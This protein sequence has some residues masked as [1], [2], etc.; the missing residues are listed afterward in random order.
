MLKPDFERR[1]IDNTQPI[2]H[3]FLAQAIYQALELGVTDTVGE[4]PGIGTAELAQRL[5]LDPQRLLGLLNFLQNEGHVLDDDGWNLTAKGAGVRPFA[6]WYEMLIGGYASTMLQLGDALRPGA[7][8]AERDSTKVGSGS[9][10]I[11]VHDTLPLVEHLLDRAGSTPETVVDLGCGD[12]AFLIEMLL[13][14]PDLRGIGVDPTAG[15]IARAAALRTT[16]GVANRLELFQGNAADVAKLDLP[17]HGRGTCFMTAF[18]LQEMLEQ[19]GEAAV[20]NLLETTFDTYPQA[21][22]LM[23]EMD[24]KPTSP[25]MGTHGLALAF[26]NPY[27]LIHS[28][29]EQ[30]LETREWWADLFDRLG[31]TCLVTANTAET[32][33]ST[34][35]EFG[36]LLARR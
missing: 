11:G 22:W 2:R 29:T 36:M 23:V 26:Y 34:G 3:F 16:R 32:V 30:R 1:L 20:E 19:E 27:F 25:V 7:P 10:A 8:W 4:L 17:D 33:D 31:L 9:C 6:A 15:S 14:R 12:A 21:Q 28:I 18:V 35:L 13:R 5:K 24:N